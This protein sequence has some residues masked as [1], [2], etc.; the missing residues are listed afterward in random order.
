MTDPTTGEYWRIDPDP[1][2]TILTGASFGGLTALFAF[3]EAPELCSSVSAQSVSLWRYQT[4]AFTESLAAAASRVGV[5]NARVRLH[6]GRYEGDMASDAATLTRAL[7]DVANWTV[8]LVIH[9]GGHDWAWWQ[10]A[11]LDDVTGFLNGKAYGDL[12]G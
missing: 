6:A 4:G 7:H 3:A 10:Q 1:R 8:P 12:D 5:H 11:M 9:E 2:R